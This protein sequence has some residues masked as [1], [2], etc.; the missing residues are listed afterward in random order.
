M[1]NMPKPSSESSSLPGSH[2]RFA[3]TRWS[4][5]VAAGQR[6]TVGSETA[7]A[8]LC[9]SY[10]YPVY[11][12]LRRR[13]Y[14]PQ[15]AQD[16]TQGFFAVLLEKDYVRAADRELGRFRTFLLTAVSRYLSKERERKRAQKRGGKQ[17]ALSLDFDAG[18]L[19]Y[20]LEPADEWT[21]E[22]LF[23]RRWALTVLDRV[24]ERLGQDYAN[25]SKGKLF[26]R[27][28]IFLTGASQLPAYAELAGELDLSEGAVKVAVHR[29]RR[30][31]RELLKQEIAGT[32]A[33]EDDVADELN[34]LLAALRGEDA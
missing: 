10:W 4:V 1:A 23:E 34:C 15:D 25:Q 2:Q 19:R 31:Y 32:V 20:Q 17:A 29:L 27:L 26:S 11:A 30:R 9:E 21:P 14:K 12:F 16:L 22:R 8:T 5:V 6:G 3:T 24:L 13:G 18:E 33:T 28:K 7:L